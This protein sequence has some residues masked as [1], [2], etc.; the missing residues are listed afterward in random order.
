MHI[1]EAVLDKSTV[2]QDPNI[3]MPSSI[4]AAHGTLGRRLGS[5]ASES[6]VLSALLLRPN[7]D[8]WV[9]G[10]LAGL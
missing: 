5:H 4:M 1:Y 10:A 2:E 3:D 8:D 6:E 9:D 7:D